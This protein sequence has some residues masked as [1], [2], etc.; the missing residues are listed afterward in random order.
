MHFNIRFFFHKIFFFYGFF[1]LMS[2]FL[3]P[4]QKKYVF[5][6]L[7]F[8]KKYTSVL[9]GRFAFCTDF[10]FG[11]DFFYGHGPRMSADVRKIAPLKLILTPETDF[12]RTLSVSTCRLLPIIPSTP[13]RH[14]R[15]R[16]QLLSS[17]TS[18]V[19]LSSVNVSIYFCRRLRR[20]F[21]RPFCRHLFCPRTL[22]SCFCRLLSNFS[23]PKKSTHRYSTTFY[24][25]SRKHIFFYKNPL[26][27]LQKKHI[28]FFVRLLSTKVRYKS[29]IQK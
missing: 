21:W 27:C 9:G 1:T 7:F 6:D 12:S 14:V 10:F 2:V 17:R 23:R 29:P 20:R 28:L 5:L 18:S 11:T 24:F 4:S 16:P 13:L 3:C 26:F 15:G 22:C 19:H 25:F 8:F